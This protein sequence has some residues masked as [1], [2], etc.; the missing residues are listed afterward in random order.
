MTATTRAVWLEILIR[1]WRLDKGMTT[2]VMLLIAGQ[3]T[4]LAMTGVAL[5]GAVAAVTHGVRSQL[6]VA[7][8]VAAGGFGL[9]W[10]GAYVLVM[11][12]SDLADRIG[13]LQIDPEVQRLSTGLPGLEHLE[14]AD[15]V[16]RLRLLVGK[17]QVLADAGWGVIETAAL[18]GQIVVTLVLLA[19][20]HPALILLGVFAIP[21]ALS[22]RVGVRRLRDTMRRAAEPTREE[23]HLHD[24]TTQPAAGKEIRVSG[25]ADRLVSRAADAWHR[26]TAVQAWGRL[27]AALVTGAGASVF[28]VGYAAVLVYVVVLVRGGQRT[29]ADLILVITLAGQLRFS[30]GQV[31]RKRTEVQA[32]LALVEPFRWL[33]SY[34]TTNRQA[35]TR[36]A[37]TSLRD[38]I[39]L[40]GVRFTYPG[41]ERQVLGPLDIDL[42]AGAMVA[43]VGGYGSGKTTLVKLLCQFYAPSA[44]RIEVD[45]TALAGIDPGSWQA[46]TTAAFQ[47]FGRYQVR[48]RH[49]VGFGDLAAADDDERLMT[50]LRQADAETVYKGLLNGLD[51][52][53]GV[54][55]DGHE[56]SEGQWQRTALARACMRQ[57]P[58]LVVLDEPTASLDPPSE[59]AIFQRHARLA[60]RLGTAFG[61]ITIVV[62]H[63]F[64][65][66]RMADLIVV[67]DNGMVVEQG[68][69]ET[70][71]ARQGTYAELY[72]MQESAYHRDGRPEPSATTDSR[73]HP[74]IS[75]RAGPPRH[76]T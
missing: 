47:D 24:M 48:L 72:R 21:G 62:S 1:S 29:V 63:R 53:L 3:V 40:R 32:G 61:T 59:H 41:T 30:F 22:G 73:R 46:A 54:L 8:L 49:A 69:H 55:F 23:R 57:S 51:S 56:L 71:M 74:S 36:P 34:G 70:L 27:H 19:T 31:M 25:V 13:Y 35:G 60:R 17:G 20:V 2:A 12:R 5:R 76:T 75:E 6:V 43:F 9:L 33:C 16:D 38:G 14:R 28:V 7:S 39:T 42:P 58:V 4:A 52:Q 68:S 66:V 11:L 65:T 64:S 67:L 37:P 10:I 18:V 26:A 45:G 44:G 15:Y 50:A